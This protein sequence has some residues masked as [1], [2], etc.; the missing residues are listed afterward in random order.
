M[1]GRHAAADDV[2]DQAFA[3][4][5]HQPGAHA[6]GADPQGIIGDGSVPADADLQVAPAT[7]A[8]RS[9]RRARGAL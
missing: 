5:P 7:E 2:D 8:P 1:T 3:D 9:G 6:A 4:R